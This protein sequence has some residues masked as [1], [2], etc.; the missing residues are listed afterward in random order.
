MDDLDQRLFDTLRQDIA[1][2]RFLLP[3]LPEIAQK[4]RE[5][6][7]SDDYGAGEVAD[8]ILQDPTI[9]A[10]LLKVANSASLQGHAPITTVQ[11]AVT[12]LGMRLVRMLVTQLCIVQLL[13]SCRDV[14]QTR[15]FVES[16]LR[17]GSI[18]Q[19]FAEHHRHLN[20]EQAMLAGLVHDIGKLPLRQY[21]ERIPRLREN[22]ALKLQII[23]RMHTRIGA[24]LL[25]TWQFPPDLVRVAAEHEDLARDYE[26]APDYTD[27]VIAANIEYYGCET[28]RYAGL[29]SP[30]IPA[31]RKAWPEDQDETR[32]AIAERL[33][34]TE[35][36]FA[37]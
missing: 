35:R 28:G 1:N 37:A 12:R 10:R 8:A 18:C 30:S 16:G 25:D 13:S 31:V 15:A 23:L 34:F 21:A 29:D 24:L 6:T 2:N 11:G 14:S 32:I 4:V 5:M 19:T 9:A 20:P 27:L 22:E 33:A 26:A 36:A 3:S 17:I 7:S